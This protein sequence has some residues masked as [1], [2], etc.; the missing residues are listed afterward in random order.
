M[1]IA[2]FEYGAIGSHIYRPEGPFIV[3][4]APFPAQ[5]FGTRVRGEKGA[6]FIFVKYAP[7]ASVTYRQGD[8]FVYDSSFMAAPSKL[9]SGYHAMGSQ[10]GV[11][12]FGG[13]VG[14][15]AS[16][17]GQG[18]VWSYAFTPGTYGIWLQINGACP[19]HVATRTAQADLAYTTAT[20]GGISQLASGASNS[21]TVTGMFSAVLTSTFTA[22]FTSGSTTA[23][24]IS[25]TVGLEVGMVLSG[26]GIPNGAYITDIQ[27]S[28]LIMS[29]A[30]T[31]TNAT[32]TV[33]WKKGTTWGTTTNGSPTITGVGSVLGIYPGAT[34][35][36]TGVSQT[37]TSITGTPGNYTITLG[38]NATGTARYRWPRPSTIEGLL[39]LPF[40]SA[41]N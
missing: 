20:V 15:P 16:V 39:T 24:N 27:G 9:G 6:E 2:Q 29:A 34:L 30:A 8:V 18:N 40:I 10:A 7:V 25:D 36:G 1:S 26:T 23:L 17:S 31:A 41:Q 22:D 28:T 37:I 21:Q 5:S 33:T 13:R 19:L 14:D 38:G 3:G 35:T 4:Q 32:V 12:F 11:L